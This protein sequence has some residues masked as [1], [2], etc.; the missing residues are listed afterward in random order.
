MCQEHLAGNVQQR[1]LETDEQ[2]SGKVLELRFSFFLTMPHTK[3][4]LSSL[5][6]DSTWPTAAKAS[7][8]HWT[9]R[10]FPFIF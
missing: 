6:R 2:S 4:D 1:R 3:W 7:P 9:V 5:T 10:E 8:N